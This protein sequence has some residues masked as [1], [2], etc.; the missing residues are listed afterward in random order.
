[1]SETP[2]HTAR[3]RHAV[4]SGDTRDKISYP[5]PA[6]APLGTDDEAAGR[7][8]PPGGP[9]QKGD[10]IA[11]GD[12]GLGELYAPAGEEDN[13]APATAPPSWRTWGFIAAGILV[14]ALVVAS[15]G[16]AA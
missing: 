10:R 3:V 4:D 2:S 6:A 15:L 12:T 14:L 8:P 1:M 16:L 13:R 9:P 11:D 5:D 7:S